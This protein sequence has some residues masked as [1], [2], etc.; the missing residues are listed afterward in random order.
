MNV[1]STEETDPWKYTCNKSKEIDQAL[2]SDDFYL[3]G[4]Q[5]YSGSGVARLF[6]TPL[7]VRQMRLGR[8]D[9]KGHQSYTFNKNSGLASLIERAY[10]VFIP[11]SIENVNRILSRQ[12]FE[13]VVGRV[14]EDKDGFVTEIETSSLEHRVGTVP[15]L[16]SL[17]PRKR[18]SGVSQVNVRIGNRT[19]QQVK[20]SNPDDAGLIEI[21]S[22]TGNSSVVYHPGKSDPP[23]P[24]FKWGSGGWKQP[25]KVK[26]EADQLFFD[27]RE[28]S[29]GKLWLLNFQKEGYKA[30]A[31]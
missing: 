17:M 22:I 6:G 10:S 12:P 26:V 29:D 28:E 14:D 24:C 8:E 30:I 1:P 7:E 3:S 16:I 4:N 23:Q 21:D 11:C 5:T 31:L 9:C 18:I 2:G 25:I 13:Y 19:I 27:E 20:S 15:D